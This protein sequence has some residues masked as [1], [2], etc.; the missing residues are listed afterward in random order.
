MALLNQVL[1]VE[2][3]ERKRAHTRLT[4]LH[5]DSQKLPL[6]AGI[7][8][9]YQPRADD[10]DPLP[11]EQ[12]NVQVTL[13]Q[14]LRQAVDDLVP[15]F[16]VTYAKDLANC[17]ARADLEV[18]GQ[19]WLHDVPVSYLLF[20]EKHLT[21]LRTFVAKLPTLDPAEN[22]SE[23]STPGVWRTDPT[24]TVRSKKIPRNHVK[25]EATDRHP[26]QVEV[27]YEDVPVG[28]WTTVKFSGALPATRVRQ[29]VDRI[30]LVLSSVKMAREK[31]NTT[32]VDAPRVA[33]ELLSALLLT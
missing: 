1:A 8:R 18:D 32:E 21:D 31:A 9:T 16:D 11:P 13:D 20:L 12:T 3:G 28:D 25:A 29:L 23:S 27:F 22:W 7:S 33:R 14:T 19:I 5:R 30:D 4:S 2:S 10:G 26:A 24:R 6:L 17:V 15:L